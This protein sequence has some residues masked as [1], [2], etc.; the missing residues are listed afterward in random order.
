M[1]V[2]TKDAFLAA[3]D[4]PITDVPL[5]AALYG[6]G[7]VA[8]LRVMSGTERAEI[9]LKFGGKNSVTAD[10]GGFRATL[11]AATW[12][13]ENGE[14]LFTAKDAAAMMSKNAGTLEK[15]VE[16]AAKLNGFREKDVET[17]EKNAGAAAGVDAPPAVPCDGIPDV[18][19]AT[20]AKA[21]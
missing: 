3:D 15:I 5:P 20:P 6:E 10:P 7:V 1:T 4:R 9:E 2:I 14:P 8:R 18:D 12:I 11:L 21:P 17:L 13:G 19:A 16:E